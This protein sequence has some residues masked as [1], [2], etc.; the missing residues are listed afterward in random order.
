MIENEMQLRKEARKTGIFGSLLFT[1]LAFVLKDKS[2]VLGY[3]LGMLCSLLIYELDCYVVDFILGAKLNKTSVLQVFYYLI[4]M[5]IYALGFLL[6][7]L[8]PSFFNLF[9]VAIGYITVKMTIYRLVMTR[10]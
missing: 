2:I 9:S 6:A 5:G 8:I 7:V 3:I 1:I 10:R 4:K